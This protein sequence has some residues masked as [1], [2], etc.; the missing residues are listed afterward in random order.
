[1]SSIIATGNVVEHELNHGSVVILAVEVCLQG[2]MEGIQHLL[3][4]TVLKS[5][6]GFAFLPLSMCLV[7]LDNGDEIIAN[8]GLGWVAIPMHLIPG[9][10][11]IDYKKGEHLLVG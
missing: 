2:M 1:M 4:L 3:E 5:T 7:L 9:W 8:D 10:Q 6:V 11:G